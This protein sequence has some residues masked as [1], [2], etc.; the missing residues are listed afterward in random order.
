[1]GKSLT[2]AGGFP[3]SKSFLNYLLSAAG[4]W[5]RLNKKTVI[6]VDAPMRIELWEREEL[7]R[8]ARRAGAK[9]VLLAEQGSLTQARQLRN[10][11]RVRA[12]QEPEQSA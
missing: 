6:V 8:R 2:L 12:E 11:V 5:I 10:R 9:V 4:R 1:M 7:L 3:S